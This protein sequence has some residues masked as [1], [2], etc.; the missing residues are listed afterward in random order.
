MPKH[1]WGFPKI[2]GTSLGVEGYSTL[3]S[4]LGPPIL[5]N[6]HMLCHLTLVDYS[7]WKFRNWLRVAG[8]L[9]N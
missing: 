9:L 1:I 7:L 4:I 2:R 6:Y 5:G 3:G 8:L